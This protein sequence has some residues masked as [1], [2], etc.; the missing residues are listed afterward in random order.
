[1]ESPKSHLEPPEAT[2][3]P[4][5]SHLEPPETQS[6]ES[7]TH[8]CCVARILPGS[9]SSP[10]QPWNCWD[11]RVFCSATEIQLPLSVHHHYNSPLT[12]V[13]GQ[14][15]PIPPPGQRL[16]L[17]CQPS[18]YPLALPLLPIP[19]LAFSPGLI[20]EAW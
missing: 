12:Y 6:C 8:P 1:M 14:V 16:H 5:G 18:A 13:P 17:L 19:F 15:V 10:H 11:L 2:W 3:S 9:S 7:P 20:L 4:L